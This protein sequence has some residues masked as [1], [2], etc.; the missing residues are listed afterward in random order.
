MTAEV[1]PM[2]V[3]EVAFTHFHTY[4]DPADWRVRDFNVRAVLYFHNG[5]RLY[6]TETFAQLRQL[7]KLK[8]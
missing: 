1:I 8:N 4:D 2:A 3:Q 7:V 6:V 5:N